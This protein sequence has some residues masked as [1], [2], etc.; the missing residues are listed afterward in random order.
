MEI[1]REVRV[2]RNGVLTAIAYRTGFQD[3]KDASGRKRLAGAIGLA[4][5]SGSPVA[6]AQETAQ[7]PTLNFYGVTGLIDTPTAQSQP[8][9]QLSMTVSHFAGITRSTLSF[10]ILPRVEGSFRYAKFESLNFAGF[11]DYFDRSFDISLRILDETRYLPAIKVGLQDFVGTGLSSG[12]YVVA[13]KTFFDDRLSVSG[14]LGWGRL[15][16][17]KSIGAPFGTR[18]SADGGRGGT[19]NAKQW[20]RGP[21]AP[22]AGVSFRATDDLTLMAEYSSDAYSIETGLS[23]G[24]SAAILDRKSPL[25]FGLN[26]R[27]NRAVNVGAYYMYGSTL[28][29]NF[30]VSLNPYDPPVRGSR[31]VAPTPVVSRP[32]RSQDPAAWAEEWALLP[33]ANRQLIA[34]LS[35]LLEPQGVIVESLA[36]SGNSVDVRVRNTHFDAGAQLVGRVAR[37]LSATMPRSVETF[38]IVP[39][40]DG[41]AASAVVIRRT[42]IEALENAPDGAAQLLAVTGVADAARRPEGDTLNPD[43]FPRFD[44]S[45]GPYLRNS[46]FDPSNPFR[47]EV[48]ARLKGSFEPVPGLVFSGSVTKKVAGNIDKSTRKPGSR[49]PGVRTDAYYYDKQGDPGLETLTAAYY[50]RPGENLYGRVTVGYLERMF[51]GVSGEVLWKPVNSRLAIG[52]ELN[53]VKQ[54]DY[55]L[56]FG[57]RDYDVVTGHVSA[58]YQFDNGFHAQLDVG[59]YLAGDIG[60]TLSIDRQFRNGWSV[61]AFATVTDVSADDFGEGSFDKGIRLSIPVSWFLGTPTTYKLGA[62]VRPVTRDGGARLAVGGRLYERVR[63]YH[64]P[65]LENQ[66]GRVWR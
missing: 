5:L 31:D 12:E 20:F 47:F 51:G 46:Y 11:E 18:P 45:L 65:V 23:G 43:L 13:T 29:V 30:T 40:L 6:L 39:S 48:G 17:Y 27:I 62:T 35:P 58:Y 56:M 8:D 2:A 24:R 3:V 26:Y 1:P 28:G 14:G 15:G 57:F 10:Q 54:R 59:R 37:A 19:F 50:F 49:L 21:A 61:G 32:A 66:W 42:D 7:H 33:D 38:R 22:F 4:V 63:G 25:N 52:G 41:M 36:S 16:S 53:Y 34:R 55:D 60:A 64:R 9:G 44:W